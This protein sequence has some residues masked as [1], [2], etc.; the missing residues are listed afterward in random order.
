MKASQWLRQVKS[1]T[2][3][4]NNKT[5]TRARK[6]LAS[7]EERTKSQTRSKHGYPTQ[8]LYMKQLVYF[9]LKRKIARLGCRYNKS[10]AEF[11]NEYC[12]NLTRG[13]KMLESIFE[14][15]VLFKLTVDGCL[16]ICSF[17]CTN[18]CKL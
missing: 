16:S 2:K 1:T 9:K 5:K 15:K 8:I 7:E 12:C 3:I 11:G 18:V 4:S 17:Y 6:R 13:I 10:I 14:E